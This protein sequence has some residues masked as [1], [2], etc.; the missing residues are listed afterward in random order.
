MT[1]ML[2]SCVR[3]ASAFACVLALSIVPG[4]TSAPAQPTGPAAGVKK[5]KYTIAVIPKD[6]N[7]EFWK[8]VHYGVREAVAELGGDEKVQIIWK[9]AD[10]PTRASAQ[11]A[12]VE[13]MIAQGVD[14]ICLAPQDS[15]A[16]IDVVRMANA[17]N[18]PVVIFDSALDDPDTIVSYV[19][20]DNFEGG[21]LGAQALA[22]SLDEKGNVGLFRYVPGSEST[23][24]REEGFLAG[25]AEYPDIKVVLSNEYSGG[26][27]A[28]ALAK[29][30]NLPQLQ[31]GEIDGMF[32]VC[33]PNVEGMLQ[34][35]EA[36]QLVGK[37]KFVG[38]DA[39]PQ[40]RKALEN[41][42]LHGLVLQDPV[43]MGKLSLKT[44]VAHLNG[45][46]VEKRI[47]T[48]QHL[49]TPENAADED[50]ARLLDP[51]LYPARGE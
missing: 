17:N 2:A 38:F 51:P 46:K 10:D 43:T 19:A 9:A 42:S 50:I 24:Q 41:G 1:A 16:L 28:E 15:Q 26:T 44:I 39:S 23:T 4:C 48:G 22:E 33:E 21:K 8:S 25:I 11:I 3:L 29:A 36:R 14:G 7:H 47:P 49:A 5:D 20:T 30:E 40:F 13:S 6:T 45:E 31:S 32:A 12:I 27:V 34:A 37:I 18:I 35:L